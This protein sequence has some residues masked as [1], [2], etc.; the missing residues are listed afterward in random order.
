MARQNYARH[1]EVEE[2]R[3]LTSDIPKDIKIGSIMEHET[4]PKLK[5]RGLID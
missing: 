2:V 3:W 1:S 4:I 5:A